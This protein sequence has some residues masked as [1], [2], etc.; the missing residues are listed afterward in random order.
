MEEL[1]KDDLLSEIKQLQERIDGDPT[2]Q[3]I[4]SLLETSKVGAEV[5]S[6]SALDSQESELQSRCILEDA[7]LQTKVD[8]FEELLQRG[9]EM[10]FSENLDHTFRDSTEKLDFTKR[11]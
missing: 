8:E 11:L 10:T 5:L 4:L 7:K 2:A 9:K 3:K 6:F 1:K